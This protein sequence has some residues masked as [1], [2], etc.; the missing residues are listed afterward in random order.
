M[1]PLNIPCAHGSRKG[2]RQP[3][4]DPPGPPRGASCAR[5][6]LATYDS[7]GT[8]SSSSSRNGTRLGASASFVVVS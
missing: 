4:S 2:E 5:F 7:L 3:W 8:A 1:A 6:E